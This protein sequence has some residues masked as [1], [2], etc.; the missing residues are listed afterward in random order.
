MADPKKY[1][2]GMMYIV[3]LHLMQQ[4]NSSTGHAR[5]VWR[6]KAEEEKIAAAAG[7]PVVSLAFEASVWLTAFQVHER[8]C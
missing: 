4:Y 2:Q 8:C 3:D 6:H 1:K 7:M 5:P